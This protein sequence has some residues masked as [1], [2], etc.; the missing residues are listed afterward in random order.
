[1]RPHSRDTMR[2]RFANHHAQKGWTAKPNH[3][4]VKTAQI[5]TG[6]NLR[7]PVCSGAFILERARAYLRLATAKQMANAIQKPAVQ[8]GP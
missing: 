5:E 1:M 8:I 6:K 7:G 3:L 4:R 2:P